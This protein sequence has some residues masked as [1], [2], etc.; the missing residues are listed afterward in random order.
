[1]FRGAHT[2]A[3][4]QKMGGRPRES[5]QLVLWTLQLVQVLLLTFDVG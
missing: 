2:F 4:G 1:M 3:F 5:R